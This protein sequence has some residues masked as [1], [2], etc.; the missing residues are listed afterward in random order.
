MLDVAQ[1]EA[2]NLLTRG[3]CDLTGTPAALIAADYQERDRRTT[4][5]QRDWAPPAAAIADLSGDST[6]TMSGAPVRQF[7]LAETDDED[8]RT[9]T[10]ADTDAETDTDFDLYQDARQS[11]A[12]MTPTTDFDL[13]MDA[14]PGSARTPTESITDFHS[15]MTLTDNE[16]SESDSD[17]DRRSVRA[18]AMSS[19][20]ALSIPK[21][22]R[23]SATASPL[24]GPSSAPPVSYDSVGV[25]ANFVDEPRIII[26]EV[27]REVVREVP[28]VQEVIKEVI[29]EVIREVPTV[30]VR[31][32][33]K[34]VPKIEIREVIKEVPKIVIQEVVKEVVREVEVIKEVPKVVEVFRDVPQ[35]A[36]STPVKEEPKPE[37]Q[38]VSTQTEEW[39]PPRLASAPVQ[40]PTP[41]AVPIPV[42]A[43]PATP[44]LYRVVSGAQ[45]FQFIP[46]PSTPAPTT[47]S[48]AVQTL[49]TSVTPVRD[50]NATYI[51]RPRTSLSERRQS[52]ESALSSLADDS[53]H[54]RSR[55][56]SSQNHAPAPV[57]PVVDKTRPPMMVLPPP[58]RLP[59][60]SN[61]PMPPPAFIPERRGATTSSASDE[62]PP[63]RPS[64]PPP[65]ELIKRATTPHL[66]SALSVPSRNVFGAR[67]HGSSMP[68]SQQG[69]RQPPSTSSFRSAVNAASPGPHGSSGAS[70]LLT[71]IG[72]RGKGGREM[73]Q[74]SLISGGSM[75]SP[76]SSMSSEHR[77]Y[78][79]QSPG[80]AS[81]SGTPGRPGAGGATDP[82]VIHS[83][84]QTMIGEFLYKYTRRAIGKGHGERRHRRFFWVHPYTKTLYWGSADPGSA[85]VTESTAKSGM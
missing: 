48:N 79:P 45:Q 61:K 33:I 54:L 46:S 34:E 53:A 10:G 26:Q 84:T 70:N 85:G 20:V 71:P 57:A 11:I 47:P 60:P 43:S 27:I 13:F 3:L 49:P 36:L 32:V 75:A 63:A 25:S 31:E 72:L 65:P 69:M 37:L 12:M 6:V 62:G 24:N 50:P 78:P 64:S 23:D 4:L 82:A 14:R 15:I 19:R 81:A 16:F 30:V 39:V 77:M 40:A 8:D 73:S 68:P 76:R 5:T 18:S 66:G 7:D 83:I 44:G 2:P 42:T 17:S 28:V 52:I 21:S 9:E 22:S 56:S 41:I 74:A 38:E 29:K 35:P 55:T 51:A 67:Q 59:P 80:Y 58:P 1:A